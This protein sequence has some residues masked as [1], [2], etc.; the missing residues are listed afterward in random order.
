[1]KRIIV[2]LSIL[3]LLLLTGCMGTP[4]IYNP[5]CNCPT[6]GP[7][8]QP[9]TMPDNGLK[10]GLVIVTKVNESTSATAET[11]GIGKYDVTIVAVTIDKEGIIQN[12][13][14]D[15]IASSVKFNQTGEITTDL[16]SEIKT[17][18]ELGADY[19]MVAW[20]GAIA[21]WDAQAKALADFAVGKTVKQLREGA[22]DETGKAPQGSD[23]ASS[24]TIY[25]GGY[26]SAIELAAE[27][28]TYSGASKGD[29]LYMATTSAIDGSTNVNEKGTGTTE[30]YSTVIALTLKDGVISSCAIDAVQAKVNFDATGTITSDL[31]ASVKTKNELGADYGMV[32][33]GGAI[34]EWDAQAASFAK[35]VTGKTIEQVMNIAVDETTKP[36]DADLSSSVT[37]KVGEFIE[38]IQKA[39]K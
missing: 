24:A 17:K 5:D 29:K 4:V 31:N 9:D 10:T 20:G 32:A 7:T 22:I 28:A 19:G 33:W 8:V 21:E 2:L 1:M 12:C 11:E 27:K 34:A 25:L 36:T 35:Y 39:T 6:D 26:V 14:I 3:S 13:I 16:A 30:L 23:L 37:I 15:G 38:L 18:N